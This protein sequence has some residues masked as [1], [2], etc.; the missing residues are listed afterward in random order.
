MTLTEAKTM[1]A[2]LDV[3]LANGEKTIKVAGREVTYFSASEVSDTAD[4]LR[5]DISSRERCNA[6]GR[7]VTVAT[8]TGFKA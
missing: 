6:G 1:L 3:A 7:C 5:R 8:W 2:A 4:R